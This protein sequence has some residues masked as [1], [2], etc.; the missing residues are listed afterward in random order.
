MVLWDPYLLDI[1]SGNMKD[2]KDKQSIADLAVE[3]Y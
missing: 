2:S 3:P 1:V